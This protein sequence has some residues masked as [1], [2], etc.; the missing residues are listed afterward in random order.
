MNEELTMPEHEH[1]AAQLEMLRTGV[2]QGLVLT[3]FSGVFIAFVV[4]RGHISWNYLVLWALTLLG[5]LVVRHVWIKTVE[6]KGLN[7]G[8]HISI[9]WKIVAGTVVTW[10]LWSLPYLYVASQVPLATQYICLMTVFIMVSVSMGTSSVIREHYVMEVGTALYPICWW[11]FISYWGSEHNIPLGILLMMGSIAL[12]IRSGAVYKN[13]SRMIE[14]NWR[15]ETL[16]LELSGL[17][18]SLRSKNREL[19]DAR[20]IQTVLA[21]SDELTG[22]FN[23]RFF[24]RTMASEWRRARRSGAPLSCIML[25]V[26]FFKPYNDNYG[27][28]AGDVALQRIATCLNDAV[29]RSGDVIAR[30]GGEEFIILMPGITAEEC[31]TVSLRIAARIKLEEIPHAFSSVSELLTASQ[32]IASCLPNDDTDGSFLLNLADE[33]LYEAKA[34]GRNTSVVKSGSP[35]LSVVKS[36]T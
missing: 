14:S 16:A 20:K 36:W 30:Y 26:D 9:F 1:F 13:Y 18:E 11:Y 32:G 10:A 19:E 6:V 7:H 33:A 17:S 22:L 29:N 12:I 4:L 25:D 27:H 31:I 23:R 28:P 21:N 2:P 15:N 24:N 34:K 35:A 8:E 3:Q 5:V